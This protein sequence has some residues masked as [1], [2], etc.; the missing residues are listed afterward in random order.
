MKKTGIFGG[1]FDPVHNGHILALMT[2]FQRAELDRVIIM[3]TGTAPHK[4]MSRL[5]TEQNRLEMAVL[6]VDGLD[7]AEV[8][9]YEIRKKSRSYTIDTLKYLKNEYK[10]DEFYLYTGSDMFLTLHQ[11]FRADEI[12]KTVV[13]VV[14]S[15]VG[16]DLEQLLSQRKFLEKTFKAKIILI[17]DFKPINISST[18]IRELIANN[19]GFEEFIPEKV[20][21]YIKN[22]N[23]YIRKTE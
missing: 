14:M 21:E 10:N 12:M 3:P 2:F 13:I 6:A 17:E 1:S 16:D 9:N 18:K 11:W 8:S 4:E 5:T 22:N 7:W 23:L 20:C 19:D 15:R